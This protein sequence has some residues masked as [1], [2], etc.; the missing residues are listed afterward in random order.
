MVMRANFRDLVGGLIYPIVFRQ[1]LSN[2]GFPWAIRTVGFLVLATYVL[3]L[4]PILFY[5]PQKSPKARSWIDVSAFTDIPFLLATFGALVGS[6]GYY[7]PILFLPLFAE[8][9]IP[10]FKNTDLAFYLV[11]I[12]NAAS[13]FGRLLAG[14]LATVIGPIETCMLALATSSLL[15][16]CWMAVNST[17]GIILWSTIWGLVSGAIVAMPGAMVPLLSPSLA[18]IGTRTGMYWVGASFG[19]LIGGPIAGA[20]VDDRST[21]IHWR[22][23]Q[24]FAGVL[25]AAGALSYIYP[26]I[27]V[28]SKRTASL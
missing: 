16:F 6:M 24:V 25:M 22:Y 20:L 13:I 12:A 23:L 11:S 3:S 19:I 8:T 4:W 15:L 5:K 28:R 9:G 1:L 27:S 18:V 17:V 2:V 21:D 7:L 14:L 10:G 26:V